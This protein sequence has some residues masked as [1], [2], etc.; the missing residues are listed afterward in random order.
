MLLQNIQQGPA[1][2]TH[3]ENI[4]SKLSLN[5]DF[6]KQGQGNFFLIDIMMNIAERWGVSGMVNRIRRGW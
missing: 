5:E 1:F 4:L 3:S 6:W 2:K